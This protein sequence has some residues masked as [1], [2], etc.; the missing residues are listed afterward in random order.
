MFQGGWTLDNLG[1]MDT[2]LRNVKQCLNLDL[3]VDDMTFCSQY[4]W[5]FSSF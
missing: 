3:Y 4:F 5:H 1:L 2:L